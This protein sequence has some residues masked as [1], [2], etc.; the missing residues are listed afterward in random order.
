MKRIINYFMLL[1]VVWGVSVCLGQ[2]AD[3]S[4]IRLDVE[5]WMQEVHF[6][7]V[8]KEVLKYISSMQSEEIRIFLA[9]AQKFMEDPALYK[10]KIQN[11][12]KAMSRLTAFSYLGGDCFV[13]QCHKHAKEGLYLHKLFV[14]YNNGTLTIEDGSSGKTGKIPL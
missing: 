12:Q 8:S 14:I 10:D 11:I 2:T 13:E 4:V 9:Q 3:E 6:N 7:L 1:V 5:H